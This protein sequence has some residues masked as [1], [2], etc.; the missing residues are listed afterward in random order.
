VIAMSALSVLAEHGLAVPDDVHVIGYD[1]L[2]IGE[3]TVPR[4]STVSQDMN[5]GAAH[6]VDLLFRRIAGEE[7]QSVVMEPEL[8][9]R[10]SS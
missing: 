3:Q 2:P 1:G 6:L 8:L 9:V 10:M 7:T 4:L 5:R